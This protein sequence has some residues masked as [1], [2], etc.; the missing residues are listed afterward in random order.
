VA[1]LNATEGSDDLFFV[2][3]GDGRHLFAPTFEQHRRN[4][5]M[6]RTV[7]PRGPDSAEAALDSVAAARLKRPPA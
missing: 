7:L 3:R 4:I 6:V 5:A 2:A 1:V